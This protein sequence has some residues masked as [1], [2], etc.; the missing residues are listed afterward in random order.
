MG[1]WGSGGVR[2]GMEVRNSTHFPVADPDFELRGGGGGGGVVTLAL[3]V[4]LPSVISSFFTQNNGAG[5]GPPSPS[6]RY[7]TD[8][9]TSA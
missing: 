8:K 9:R 2:A 4:F 5:S 6:H 3:P 7:A 1:E